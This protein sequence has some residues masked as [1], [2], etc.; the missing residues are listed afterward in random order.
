MSYGH[1]PIVAIIGRAVAGVKS[2]DPE[3]TRQ[4]SK[5]NNQNADKSDKFP[6]IDR[7]QF[8]DV[9]SIP[10]LARPHYFFTSH[11]MIIRFR[12]SFSGR[13]G[14]RFN[15]KLLFNLHLVVFLA[16]MGGACS[17]ASA[18]NVLT[19][20]QQIRAL[21]PAEAQ[22]YRSVKLKATIS[23]RDPRAGITF[24]FDQTGG[25]FINPKEDAKLEAG[26]QVEIS[27][28]AEQGSRL[29]FVSRATVRVI[30]KAPLPPAKKIDAKL[31]TSGVADSEWVQIEGIVR[32]DE[33][34]IQVRADGQQI[35]LWLLKEQLNTLPKLPIGSL[36]KVEGVGGLD[37]KEDGSHMGALFVPGKEHIEIL[38]LGPSNT[39]L[40][41]VVSVDQLKQSPALEGSLV[42]LEG[43][44]M[45]L[46]ADGLLVVKD[47][48]GTFRIDSDSS[49][50]VKAN[51]WVEVVGFA[52]LKSEI[53]LIENVRMRA[54]GPRLG[55]NPTDKTS[56]F[57]PVLFDTRA[58]QELSKSD[59]TNGWPVRLS[60][61]VTYYDPATNIIAVQDAVSGIFV[62]PGKPVKG[63]KVGDKVEV[64][65]FSALGQNAHKVQPAFVNII[66]ESQLPI[67]E[68]VG[69]DAISSRKVE[70]EYVEVTGVVRKVTESSTITKLELG[71]DDGLLEAY[72]PGP[73]GGDELIDTEVSIKGVCTFRP[74]TQLR[75][76]EHQ[77]WM[78][79][80][81]G[82]VILSRPARSIQELAITPAS[83]LWEKPRVGSIPHRIHMQGQ[84]TAIGRNLTY[85]QDSTGAFVVKTDPSLNLAEGEVLDLFGFAVG[86]KLPSLQHVT[87]R[88]G[89]PAA[90]VQPLASNPGR[91]LGAAHAGVLLRL[92]GNLLQVQKRES[93]L[94]LVLRD[95][96]L[97]FEAFLDLSKAKDLLEKLK[98]DSELQLTG[99][100]V[101]EYDAIGTPTSFRMML[102]SPQDLIILEAPSWW[103]PRR[104]IVFLALLLLCVLAA[105]LWAATLRRK[106][107]SQTQLIKTRL[108]REIIL[109]TKLTRMVDSSLIGIVFWDDRMRVIDA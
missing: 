38:R 81:N 73:V 100:S 8:V 49:L 12:R 76:M 50:P 28:V 19:N 20:I 35:K 17:Q 87:L 74:A 21:S 15:S 99:V 55:A 72:L 103:T 24:I 31:L 93:D 41:D 18:Q 13:I 58:V 53:P 37:L 61:I 68:K 98:P 10:M 6:L 16:A 88:P 67:P 48:T 30:G 101:T 83:E 32:N 43:S 11:R 29:P 59:T 92:N 102:R 26:D 86:G 94:V 84:V 107:E 1:Q 5:A 25:I 9:S 95:G 105:I 2:P 77:L 96:F 56:T 45:G 33:R 39:E 65:G 57:L 66:G 44:V 23:Y 71:V 106:L 85:L 82:L 7:M 63:L 80:R 64:N 75:E 89:I 104:L 46:T 69:L 78:N 97:V 90:P 70:G 54:R 4:K 60:A 42:R 109:E 62:F 79:A 40:L 91:A 3:E 34:V 52:N 27:G 47:S 22:T 51:D 14:H 108:E 36:I